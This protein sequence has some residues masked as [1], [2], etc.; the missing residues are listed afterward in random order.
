MHNYFESSRTNQAKLREQGSL[1]RQIIS[2]D[3]LKIIT[4]RKNKKM[5]TITNTSIQKFILHFFK[6]HVKKGKSMTK[7]TVF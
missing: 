7:Y 5:T 3:N 2:Q 1:K 4:Q 6:F